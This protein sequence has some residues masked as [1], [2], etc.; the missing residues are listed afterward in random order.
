M[1]PLGL[2]SSLNWQMSYKQVLSELGV[3]NRF[4]FNAVTGSWVSALARAER[5]GLNAKP[6]RTGAK[7]VVVAIDRDFGRKGFWLPL[8]AIVVTALTLLT[9]FVL[10]PQKVKPTSL[11]VQACKPISEGESLSYSK[12]GISLRDWNLQLEP[13]EKLGGMQV[14]NL[15]ATCGENEWSGQIVAASSDDHLKI[16]RMAPTIR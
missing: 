4:A 7:R 3:T 2:N 8:L 1:N 12:Q 16:K 5:L 13:L 11:P 9:S 14:F 15:L 10:R 6:I